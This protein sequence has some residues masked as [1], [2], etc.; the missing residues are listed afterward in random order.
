M[1]SEWVDSDVPSIAAIRRELELTDDCI[2]V[3]CIRVRNLTV[4][5]LHTLCQIIK[6]TLVD[7]HANRIRK[8]LTG[9]LG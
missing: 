9:Q 3:S 7:R 6:A 5:T 4:L 8:R 1:D 2:W